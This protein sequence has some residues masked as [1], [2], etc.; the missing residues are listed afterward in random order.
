MTEIKA[1]TKRGSGMLWMYEHG[2]I[3]NSIYD[4]YEKPSRNKY[5]AFENCFS[6]Y[7]SEP[8]SHGF[9]CCGHNSMTFSVAW[10]DG[11]GNLRYE[12]KENSYIIK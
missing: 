5:R 10:I 9:K 6:M 4:I 12:T 8:G 2:N 3:V 11:N 7:A 1:T